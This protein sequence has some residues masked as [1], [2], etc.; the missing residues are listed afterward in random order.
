MMGSRDHC[1]FKYARLFEFSGLLTEDR[2]TLVARKKKE[3]EERGEK[4]DEKTL[5]KR[6]RQVVFGMEEDQKNVHEYLTR[7]PADY[8]RKYDYRKL[9][10]E[11]KQAKK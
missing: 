9:A 6:P 8:L 5:D 10:F 7:K 2:N 1:F 11:L 3:A 4:F